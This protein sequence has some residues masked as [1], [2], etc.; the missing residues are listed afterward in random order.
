MS[1]YILGVS[2]ALLSAI[3]FSLNSVVTRRG[4]YEGNVYEAVSAS[5]IVGIPIFFLASI[6]SGEFTLGSIDMDFYVL[7]IIVGIL[8]FIIG[9]YLLYSSIHYIG[10]AASTP[11]TGTT[12]VFAVIMAF[13][14]LRE[15]I[16]F[17]KGIGIILSISGIL[18]LIT[19]YIRITEMKRGLFSAL[20][21]TFFFATTSILIRYGLSIYHRPYTAILIS[22]LSAILIFFSPSNRRLKESIKNLDRNILIYILIA[23]FLVDIGQ[24]LRYCALSIVEVSIV[25]PIFSSIPIQVLIYSYLINRRYEEIDRW[26]ILSTGIIT[27]G[28]VLVILSGG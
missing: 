20:S 21:A 11:I 3:F 5:I 15:S 28:V 19:P 10:A 26:K 4:V 13:L 22:Y 12:Q 16:N 25:S 14:I 8:H 23:A 18:I 1:I 6:F 2:Y 24:L 9:R 7:F 17:L 27:I